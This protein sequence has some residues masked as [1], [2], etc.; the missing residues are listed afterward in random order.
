MGGFETSDLWI[1]SDPHI[2]MISLDQ[3]VVV[4]GIADTIRSD[5]VQQH[6]EPRTQ[7]AAL[8]GPLGTVYR[9]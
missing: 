1:I 4:L 2:A 6:L 8:D 5:A 9:G 7:A 3:F